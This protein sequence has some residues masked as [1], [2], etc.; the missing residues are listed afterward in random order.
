MIWF[1]KWD[2]QWIISIILMKIECLLII[3]E[4]W[5]QTISHLQLPA[6]LWA[7]EMQSLCGS[8]LQRLHI[9]MLYRS[10][11]NTTYWVFRTTCYLDNAILSFKPIATFS[12]SRNQMCLKCILVQGFTPQFK[13]DMR[14][15]WFSCA[16]NFKWWCHSITTKWTVS[17]DFLAL[18]FKCSR[19]DD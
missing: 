16:E 19:K 9:E 6:R 7:S 12:H 17:D 8:S 14:I 13:V 5:M 18:W 11:P 15:W 4:L 3:S 10:I 1:C 2:L